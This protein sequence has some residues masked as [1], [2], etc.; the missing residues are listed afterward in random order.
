MKFFSK[1]FKAK[2]IASIFII[3]WLI[4]LVLITINH[5]LSIVTPNGEIKESYKKFI[6]DKNKDSII[7]YSYY[8]LIKNN[9]KSD[10]NE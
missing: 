7:R 3:I 9:D 8:R 10:N 1:I 5:T 4:I 6:K 2:V